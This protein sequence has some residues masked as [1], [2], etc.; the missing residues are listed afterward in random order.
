MSSLFEILVEEGVLAPEDRP[1][2]DLLTPR[3]AQRMVDVLR[4][5]TRHI[6]LILEAVDDGH[7]QAAVLRSAD[8]FGVQYVGV[9]QGRAPFRPN[10]EVTQGADKWL[11]VQ[12]FE[13]IEAAIEAMRA[14]GYRVWASRLDENAV[15]LPDVD[16][17]TPAAFLFGNEHD[18]VSEQ[19][20]AL[21][22]GSFVIPMVGFV[23]SLNV[24]V[25]AAITMFH[26][27][28]RARHE[29]GDAYYLSRDE[30]QAVLRHWLRTTTPQAARLARALE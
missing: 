2:W 13:N 12:R 25:A 17:S 16:L 30:Q 23:Q 21:A 28:R 19:A 14:R 11:T 7:N 5:R 3:R 24:S 10:P 1:F 26:V 15:P 18:G 9:V 20:L 27:T 6:A 29:V 4:Q 8:A 22:D